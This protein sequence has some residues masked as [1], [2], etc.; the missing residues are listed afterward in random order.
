MLRRLAEVAKRL[1][2]NCHT[3]AEDPAVRQKI[4]QFHVETE[5]I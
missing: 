5:A 3:A 2:V 1:R 4:A